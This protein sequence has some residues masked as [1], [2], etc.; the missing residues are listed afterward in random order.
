MAAPIRTAIIGNDLQM[1][2]AFEWLHTY[3]PGRSAGTLVL[4]GSTGC[5]KTLLWSSMC[6]ASNYECV[7]ISRMN[8]TKETVSYALQN[9]TGFQRTIGGKMLRYAI[10][11]DDVDILFNYS[12]SLFEATRKILRGC[13]LPKIVVSNFKKRRALKDFLH[14]LDASNLLRIHF[15]PVP[16]DIIIQYLRQVQKNE[17]I[18]T[19]QSL[20]DKIAHQCHGDIRHALVM[21]RTCRSIGDISQGFKDARLSTRG[22]SLT[23]GIF[24]GFAPSLRCVLFACS[25]ENM[26]PCVW[27][28]YLTEMKKLTI[29][30]MCDIADGFADH[31]VLAKGRQLAT[32]GTYELS[33]HMIACSIWK[34]GVMYRVFPLRWICGADVRFSQQQMQ[35]KRR[36]RRRRKCIITQKQKSIWEFFNKKTSV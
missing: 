5:G 7:E 26:M 33:E 29:C 3:H 19:P 36:R 11:V 1:D 20:C 32:P 9:C 34:A 6:R 27:G 28:S 35:Y 12:R 25:L 24:D 4:T 18:G 13:D 14:G 31:D 16:P 30:Q 15:E 21:I 23:R 22:T 8:H 10:V 2:Q 17:F